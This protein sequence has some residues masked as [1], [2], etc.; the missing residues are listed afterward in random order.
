MVGNDTGKVCPG[1]YIYNFRPIYLNEKL[2]F[3]LSGKILN[4][5]EMFKLYSFVTWNGTEK[6][7]PPWNLIKV[8]R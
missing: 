1:F 3:H 4:V 6:I 2:P 8:Q 5:L 7:L